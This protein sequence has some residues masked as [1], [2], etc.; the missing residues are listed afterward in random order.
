[1]QQDTC[2]TV[3]CGRPVKVKSRQL[4]QRCYFN[5]P[6]GP[7]CSA[8]GCDRRG[9]LSRG[10]C[11]RCRARVASTGDP[12]VVLIR[13]KG[14]SLAELQAA[15][16]ATTDECIILS[17][18]RPGMRHVRFQGKITPASRAVWTIANGEPGPLHVLHTCNGGSGAHGCINIRHLFLGDAARNYR[19]KVAAGRLQSTAGTSNGHAKLTDDDVREIR[20]R[21]VRGVNQLDTGNSLALS[22]E[23]GIDRS[24]LLDIVRRKSWKHVQ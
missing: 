13:P 1:M 4:C 12:T 21:Y 14:A 6:D 5:R 15:A 18:W 8:L 24:T 19:D 20:R 11:P 9:Q 22:H 16:Q 7:Q 10:L 17:I 3:G 2:V 23:Y